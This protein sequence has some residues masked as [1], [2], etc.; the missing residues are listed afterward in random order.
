MTPFYRF[1]TVALLGLAMAAYMAAG[2]GGSS[3]A[4]ASNNATANASAA[5]DKDG[6]GV[7][8][9]KDN[10]PS[11]KNADQADAD[12]DGKGDVCDT[13]A[14]GSGNSG[15]GSDGG[16]TVTSSD[17]NSNSTSGDSS[18]GGGNAG[19][20]S[21]G[22]EAPAVDTDQDGVADTSDNCPSVANATQVNQDGDALGDVCDDDQDGDS[23]ANATDNCATTANA[24]QT[25][26]DG[27][28]QGD[29]CDTDDDNDGVADT[30]D[31]CPLVANPN[32][33]DNAS[34]TSSI[35]ADKIGDACQWAEVMILKEDVVSNYPQPV[36]G[37]YGFHKVPFGSEGKTKTTIYTVGSNAFGASLVDTPL[38]YRGDYTGIVSG[39]TQLTDIWGSALVDSTVDNL[40]I[41][42]NSSTVIHYSATLSKSTQLAAPDDV[43]G[44]PSGSSLLSVW[45]SG[46][47]DIYI[48][49]TDSTFMTGLILHSTGDDTWTQIA[50]PAPYAYK[51]FYTIFGFDASNVFVAGKGNV[52]LYYNGT[53][54]LGT[55]T[56]LPD[57]AF[58]DKLWGS[59]T[60]DL[61]AIE[62]HSESGNF[63]YNIIHSVDFGMTWSN[64]NADTIPSTGAFPTCIWGYVSGGKTIVYFPMSDGT[65]KLWNGTTLSDGSF[66]R[67]FLPNRMFG[68][69]DGKDITVVGESGTTGVVLHIGSM[70][71]AS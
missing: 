1:S 46:E 36:K 34:P 62:Y 19:G 67:S 39:T 45:G 38:M 5:S 44:I 13:K 8:D 50:T 42:G 14:S 71:D 33:A 63:V 47:N 18:S 31:N 52:V 25:D 17:S 56:N 10:C 70:N 54:W 55:E 64:L 30:T 15:S 22:N 3:P 16:T 27:D 37:V 6:D 9:S 20:G 57:N 40:Y 26:T 53:E 59:S 66:G 68:S 58:I 61:Y 11:T 7:A 29:A 32:Q 12:K 48:V 24:N 49:G 41:I 60:A 2:C 43:T 51:I 21:T 65:Y 4:A 35:T 69:P 23:V 28:T